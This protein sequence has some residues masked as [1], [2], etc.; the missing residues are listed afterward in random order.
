MEKTIRNIEYPIVPRDFITAPIFASKPQEGS[1]KV[2]VKGK[3]YTIG[4]FKPI[5]E[6][7]Q[8]CPAL[9]IRHGRALFT[10][11]SFVDVYEDSPCVKFSINEFCKRYA[12]SNGGRYSRD[13]KAI[14]SDLERCWFKITD[15][16]GASD[17]YRILKNISVHCKEPRKKLQKGGGLL[18]QE[19]MWLDE[20]E[21]HPKFYE[22]LKDYLNVAQIHL[23][24]LASIRSPLAQAIYAYI[25]SRAVHCSKEMPFEITLK[26]ILIQVG[27][28]IPEAKSVR[29]KIFTQ[30]KN[31]VVQQLN[32]VS[33]V[34]GILKVTLEETAS[35]NDYKLQFWVEKSTEKAS[36][37]GSKPQGSSV[38]RNLWIRSGKSH[39]EFDVRIRHPLPNFS[40]YQLELFEKGNIIL[41]GNRVFFKQALALLG[42]NRFNELLAEAKGS[43]LEGKQAIKSETH[44]LIYFVKD[45]IGHATHK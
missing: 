33:I 23:K 2:E 15:E 24:T 1:R 19:E 26:N 8:A 27:H 36:I 4:G 13:I 39:Q 14:L 12:S 3:V 5:S 40:N 38:L 20:V 25:P 17:S 9:D 18:M 34:S 6:D 22:L 31:S 43:V 29:K 11:L 37:S 42:E 32:N 28:T 10:I 16:F 21:L 45:A 41:K 35:Q 30:N 7:R 44:R